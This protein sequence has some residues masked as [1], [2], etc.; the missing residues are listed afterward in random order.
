[1]THAEL[2]ATHDRLDALRRAEVIT[3]NAHAQALQAASRTPGAS[4]WRR[5]LK[6]ASTVLGAVLIVSAVI[7]FFAYNWSALGPYA[8]L[9]LI[10]LGL[11]LAA[12][13]AVAAGPARLTGR[14]AYAAGAVLGGVL[15]AVIGQAY[16]TDAESWTLYAGWALLAVPWVIGAKWAPTWLLEIVLVNVALVRWI[17][18]QVGWDPETQAALWAAAGLSLLNGVALAVWERLATERRWMRSALVRRVLAL[19]LLGPPAVFISIRVLDSGNGFGTFLVWWGVILIPDWAP[20][21]FG[22]HRK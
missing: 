21:Q 13:L 5:F 15:L 17:G 19:G 18:G 12:G 7:Y 8:R 11:V 4:A 6:L 1:M 22:K 3:P 16:P 20:K 10:G 9:S 14:L 2:E